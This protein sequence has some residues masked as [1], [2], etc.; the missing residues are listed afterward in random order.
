MVDCPVP[1]LISRITRGCPT[2]WQELKKRYSQLLDITEFYLFECCG[3][4]LISNDISKSFSTLT[5]AACL[6]TTAPCVNTKPLDTNRHSLFLRPFARLRSRAVTA[7]QCNQ[8]RLVG[9]ISL[10]GVFTLFK[11]RERHP[12]AIRST[13][14]T[15]ARSHHCCS[16]FTISSHRFVSVGAPLSTVLASCKVT[17][18]RA[19]QAVHTAGIIHYIYRLYILQA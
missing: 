18:H 7:L 14:M 9:H 6:S 15:L 8:Q 17:L 2:Y 10:S 19:E 4:R 1:P 5:K 16:Q 13:V 3:F 12:E 11:A